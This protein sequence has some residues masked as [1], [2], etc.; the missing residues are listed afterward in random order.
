M[1]DRITS[2]RLRELI[3]MRQFIDLEIIDEKRRLAEAARE[4]EEKFSDARVAAMVAVLLRA[5]ADLY[6]VSPAE[7]LAH[8]KSRSVSNARHM[9]AWLLRQKGLSYSAIGRHLGRDHSTV[10]SACRIIDADGMRRALGRGILA[11][12]EAA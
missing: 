10:I 6:G 8:D 3:H 5:A 4:A 7:I 1:T 11:R 9:A 2:V 12:E